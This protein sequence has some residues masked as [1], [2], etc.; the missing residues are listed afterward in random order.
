MD[1]NGYILRFKRR[2]NQIKSLLQLL[3][4]EM[5]LNKKTKK[6]LTEICNI[7][8]FKEEETQKF[9]SEKEK[10]GGFKGLFKK[11]EK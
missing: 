11:K 10:K 2:F 3:I 9:L 7:S 8:G 4:H 6:I 1:R 5:D